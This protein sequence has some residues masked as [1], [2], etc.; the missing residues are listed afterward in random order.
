VRPDV[1]GGLL[2]AAK[3]SGTDAWQ[4]MMQIMQPN[5]R[6]YGRPTITCRRCGTLAWRRTRQ[7]LRSRSLQIQE[8]E[9]GAC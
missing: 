9:L 8:E 7:R 5:S 1:I 3:R 4:S 6:S 2:A